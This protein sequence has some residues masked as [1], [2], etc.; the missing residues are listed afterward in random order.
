MGGGQTVGTLAPEGVAPTGVRALPGVAAVD[1]IRTVQ[2]SAPAVDGGTAPVSLVVTD[3]Q[4]RRSIALYRY[5]SGDPDA[6]WAQLQAGAVIVSEPYAFRQ[7]VPPQGGAVTLL[8]D[9]GP[10]GF[11][12]AAIYYDYASD[13]GRVQI[14]RAVYEQYWDDRAISALAVY[15]APGQALDPLAET[16]RAALADTALQVQANRA[17]RDQALVVFDR[18]FAITN[19]LR[20]LAVV[21]AFIGVLSALLALQLERARELATL[22]A[23][24]LT[25][26]QLWRLT[27]LETGLMGLAAGLFSL[28]TG[29]ILAV[30]LVY[31]IN[32]RSF[33]WTIEMQRDAGGLSCRRW[34]SAS[35]RRCWPPSTRCGGC[36]AC[37]SRRPCVR[38]D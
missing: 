3:S 7:H 9:R 14:S 29:Y 36:C 30:V 32:L 27:F 18:T 25:P 1:T 13:Q 35:W 8:T 20:L 15:A 17:L 16:L 6:I 34:S 28:P 4:E 37:R 31:V 33:G 21:V 10:H 12:V 2:V 19:A 22:Q 38:S 5:A 24:G 11:P 23:L 26:G